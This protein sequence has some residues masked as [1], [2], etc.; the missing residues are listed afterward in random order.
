[1]TS[2]AGPPAAD[3]RVWLALFGLWLAPAVTVSVSPLMNS[4]AM[5]ARGLN[6]AAIGLARTLET[7]AGASLT[8]YLATILGRLSPRRLGGLGIALIFIGNAGAMFGE[9]FGDLIAARIAAGIGSACMMAAG[10]ALVARVKSPQRVIGALAAPITLVGVTAT[11]AAGALARDQ[12]QA[13][14]F[15]VVAFC[16]LFALPFWAFASPRAN[17]PDAPRGPGLL[18]FLSTLRAPYVIASLFCF[19]GGTATWAFFARMGLRLGLDEAEIGQLIAA[20]SVGSGILAVIGA[21]IP[22]RWA[23]TI[24]LIAAGVYMLANIG[25]ALSTTLPVYVGSFV[26]VSM[27][28][29]IIQNVFTVVGVRS[30]RTGGLNAAGN[31]WSSLANAAAPAS[32]GALIAATGSF[33]PLSL[34]VLIVGVLTLVFMGMAIRR[35]AP[36]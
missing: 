14:A 22:D 2:Q 34:I 6:E 18:A 33:A 12:G 15:G 11:I 7:L 13:G 17:A 28:Y 31:G 5:D 3:W 27:S 25:V 21:A 26:F 36:L 29:V 4:A 9:G 30:D 32:A 19:V 16:A 8:I 23:P 24:A 1:M 20:V 35:L 10:S